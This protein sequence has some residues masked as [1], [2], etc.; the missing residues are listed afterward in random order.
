MSD[1]ILTRI[2]LMRCNQLLPKISLLLILIS[3]VGPSIATANGTA[4]LTRYC[5][6]IKDI[7]K[8]DSN[9]WGTSGGNFR[10]F[11]TSLAKK[12]DQFIGAQ[13]QG[14]NLGYVTCVYKPDN[15]NL[16]YVTLM[17][18][19]L[20]YQPV[21]KNTSWVQSKKGGWL[22]CN[23]TDQSNCP[24]T[25]RPKQKTQDIYKEAEQLKEET[26]SYDNSGS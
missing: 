10:S 6:A 13:W 23:A 9:H 17:Y 19:E 5:P 26:N 11:E 1:L 22:N 7:Y 25:I 3:S 14:A 12:L 21:T 20:T 15:P 16:F 2:K 4:S 18:N 8:S 24:F